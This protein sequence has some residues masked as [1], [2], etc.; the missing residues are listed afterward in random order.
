MSRIHVQSKGVDD[1]KMRLHSFDCG[2]TGEFCPN[3]ENCVEEENKREG[4]LSLLLVSKR[5]YREAID[6]L[7]SRPTFHFGTRKEFLIFTRS[8][9]K[10]HLNKIRTISIE[11]FWRLY[12]QRQY[13]IYHHFIS[14]TTPDLDSAFSSMACLRRVYLTF[15]R[16]EITHFTKWTV[17]EEHEY[18]YD[19]S[20]FP[21]STCNIFMYV[22]MTPTVDALDVGMVCDLAPWE[23]LLGERPVRQLIRLRSREES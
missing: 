23:P 3:A 8:I 5:V 18:F 10:H 21:L 15:I 17:P 11:G 9:P 4:I 2:H 14:A 7:Y 1:D 12:D 20:D 22:D 16:T 19:D 13:S 6:A